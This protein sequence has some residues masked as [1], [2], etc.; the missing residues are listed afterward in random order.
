MLSFNY[1]IYLFIVVLNISYIKLTISLQS[2]INKKILFVHPTIKSHRIYTNINTCYQMNRLYCSPTLNNNKN[3]IIIGNKVMNNNDNNVVKPLV[4]EIVTTKTI[5]ESRGSIRD[6]QQLQQQQ[7]DGINDNISYETIYND[8]KEDRVST[9]VDNRTISQ[10]LG[11]ITNPL[12]LL[13]FIYTVLLGYNKVVDTWNNMISLIF[14]RKGKDNS[15]N[16]NT[17]NKGSITSSSSNTQL[18]ST[19]NTIIDLP[20]QIYEC[21]ICQMQMRP[22]KGRAEKIFS[23][24]RFRCARCGSKASAYFNIDDMNDTRAV[25]R[26]ERLQQEEA[27]D[28]GDDDE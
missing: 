13:L 27:D 26:M 18:Q 7:H 5:R 11:L 2:L 15:S 8:D 24:E 3:E 16:S 1:F 10:V 17:N 6:D 22:A 23:R 4:I 12:A 25:A 20:F 28:Y 14:K 21:E 19:V 9:I